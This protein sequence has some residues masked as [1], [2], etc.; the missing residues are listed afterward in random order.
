MPFTGNIDKDISKASAKYDGK[1]S[2]RRSR[3]FYATPEKL[4]AAP[5][6][7]IFEASKN[8]I[9]QTS[10]SFPKSNAPPFCVPFEDIK[11]TRKSVTTTSV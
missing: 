3:I 7:S 8:L 9:D 4:L 10:S 1:R 11:F 5:P 6:V 2:P